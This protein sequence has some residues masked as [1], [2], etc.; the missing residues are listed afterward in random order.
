MFS[1]TELSGLSCSSLLPGVH[2]GPHTWL[3]LDAV[4]CSLITCREFAS[5]HC[6]VH[7]SVYIYIHKLR[8]FFFLNCCLHRRSWAAIHASTSADQNNTV[9]IPHEKLKEWPPCFLHKLKPSNGAE[10][11]LNLHKAFKI[12]N[13][14][15][16][17]MMTHQLQLNEAY[18]NYLNAGSD[19]HHLAFNWSTQ[20]HLVVRR[21]D[22]GLRAKH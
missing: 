3:V 20:Y 21:K 13:E 12:P 4:C 1:C 16:S 18:H 19:P 5:L 17:L 9:N 22:V 10:D 15:W 14:A 6:V 7:V 11:W 8:P 2:S